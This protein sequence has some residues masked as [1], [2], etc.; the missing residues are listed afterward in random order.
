MISQ[1]Y[2]ECQLPWRPEIDPD[3]GLR[4]A[5]G[6]RFGTKAN[7]FLEFNRQLKVKKRSEFSIE[8][9]TTHRNG[10]IFYIANERNVD[11]IALYMKQGRVSLLLTCYIYIVRY[12]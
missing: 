5:K 11:F 12:S 3:I 8:F 2:G 7:T 9:K 4:K 1:T 10:I 6:L